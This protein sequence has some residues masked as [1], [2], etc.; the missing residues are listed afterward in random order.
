M[1]LQDLITNYIIRLLEA[2]YTIKATID[3]VILSLLFG[4]LFALQLHYYLR[5]YLSKAK[6]A[7]KSI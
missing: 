1:Y 7:R 6:L 5:L 3:I 4:I 2:C